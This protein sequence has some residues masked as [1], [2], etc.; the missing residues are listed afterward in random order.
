LLTEILMVSMPYHLH[1]PRKLRQM[2]SVAR[3]EIAAPVLAGNCTTLSPEDTSLSMMAAEVV[4]RICIRANQHFFK[5]IKKLKAQRNP[6]LHFKL[7]EPLCKRQRMVDV[8]LLLMLVVEA[9]S[10]GDV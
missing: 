10:M 5:G 2:I 1:Q 4:A 6:L 3:G 9:V 8:G 7:I